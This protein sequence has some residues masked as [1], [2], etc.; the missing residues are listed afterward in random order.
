MEIRFF[1]FKFR[2]EILILIVVVWWILFGHTFCGCSNVGL[3]EG[4]EMVKKNGV[5]N[6]GMPIP[7]TQPPM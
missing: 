2:V 4:L 5:K 7:P 6:N 1:G 3:I